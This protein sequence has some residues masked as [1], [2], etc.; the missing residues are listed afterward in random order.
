MSAIKTL[1]GQKKSSVN[2]LLKPNQ[3]NNILGTISVTKPGTIVTAFPKLD[4]LE[5]MKEI[6][7]AQEREHPEQFKDTFR[8]PFA[9]EKTFDIPKDKPLGAVAGILS[10][11]PELTVSLPVAA[12]NFVRKNLNTIIAGKPVETEQFKSILGFDIRRFGLN[13]K[14]MQ[15]TATAAWNQALE[16]EM[17]NPSRGDK[18]KEI[19]NATMAVSKTV[20]PDVLDALFGVD[21]AK[22]LL[23]LSVGG[24]RLAAKQLPENLLFKI[25]E[26]NISPQAVYDVLI[27]GNRLSNPVEFKIAIDFI[28]GLSV[29]ERIQ[30]W[31]VAKS[32]E[33]T[34]LPIPI[35]GKATPTA[36]GKFAGV[37]AP[38]TKLPSRISGL[39]SERASSQR[40]GFLN[41][42]AMGEEFVNLAKQAKDIK[43]FERLLSKEQIG[44]LVAKGFTV[45]T[46]FNT[47]KESQSL[48]IEARKYK[49]AEEFVKAQGVNPVLNLPRSN[50]QGVD[51][52]FATEKT[53]N[54]IHEFELPSGKKTYSI[55]RVENGKN[56]APRTKEKMGEMTVWESPRFGT[57]EEAQNALKKG[58]SSFREEGTNTTLFKQIES[59]LTETKSQLT[60]FYN[61]ATKGVPKASVE[62]KTRALTQEEF[63]QKKFEESDMREFDQ[64]ATYEPTAKTPTAFLKMEHK[65]EIRVIKK[66]IMDKAG[67]IYDSK[68]ANIKDAKEILSRRR[69]F[70]KAI[71]KQF[72]LSDADLKTITRRDIRLMSNVEFKEFLDNIRIKSE[73]LSEW[74]QAKNELV[75]QIREKELN[76]EPLRESMKL[77]PISKMSTSQ[78]QEFAQTLE[79]YMKSDIFLSKRKLDTIKLTELS[80][81]KTYR[82]ALDI[83]AKK[84]GVKPEDL[85]NIKISEFDRFKGHVALVEKDPFFRMMVEETTR[86]RLIREAEYLEIEGTMNNLA[87]KIKTTLLQKLIPQQKNIRAWFEATDKNTI[88]L[89]EE[90]ASVVKFMQEEWIRARDYLIKIKALQKG[91]KSDNYFT[92]IRRGILEAVKEDGIITAI[93]EVFQ[94]YNLDEQVFSIVDTETGQI[95]SMEKFFQFALRRTGGLIPTENIVG[96]FL[97]YMKTFKKKQ[98][99]D[100]IVPLIDIYANALTPK[101]LTESGLL[102]HGNLTRFIKEWLNTQKGSRITLMARHGGKI[103]WALRAGRTFT[104]LL[105]LG[106]NIPVTIATQI[107]E[108]AVQYQILGKG[109]FIRGKVRALTPRG[110]R[111]AKKY[112]N[113][114]GKNPWTQLIEPMRD[115]GDRLSE[116]MFV[117]FHDANVRRNRNIMLGLMIKEEWVSETLSPERLVQLKISIARYGVVSGVGSIVGATP[118]AGM[119]TQYKTWALPIIGSQLRNVS[120]MA[121]FFK[122]RGAQEGTR[123]R[124]ALLETYRMLELGAFVSIVGYLVLTNDDDDSIIGKLKKRAYQEAMTLFGATPVVF[125]VPRMATFMT[126]LTSSIASILK[127]EKY[128]T[129]KFGEYEA[130]DLKGTRQLQ[131]VLT[132]RAIKQFQGTKTK[133]IDDV[134]GEIKRDIESG[135]LTI[136]A[137]KE[138]LNNELSKLNT[139]EQKAR[140]NMTLDDYKKDIRERLENKEI[141][142]A[143]AKGEFIKYTEANID[144][145]RSPN[146]GSFIDK[147]ILH[148]KAIGT[149]PIT[150]FIF[151]FQGETIRKIENGTIIVER[152]SLQ[153]SQQ[154]KKELG[155]GELILDHTIPLELGGGNGKD[156]LKLVSVDEWESYTSVENYLGDKLRAGLIDKKTAQKLILQ[157]KDKEISATDIM[158]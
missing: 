3:D 128:K 49:S 129:S 143:E 29:K 10:R 60:D 150:A 17:R 48:I 149:D 58:T 125:S 79:P 38:A 147:I 158:K 77:P 44:L 84:L 99:L 138:K 133:T 57:L 81:I 19:V 11:V 34:G 64:G 13:D 4:P 139:A 20:V 127:L 145:F 108:Q 105:D 54:Y 90:E 5:T 39:L 152:M 151:L 74:K 106:L 52:Y 69:T 35:R 86:L 7:A 97:T 117:M 123:G 112:R 131:R 43:E 115:I 65:D 89:T 80:G 31:S 21:V 126:D 124:R 154:V 68:V 94:K 85:N 63:I 116:G 92:H 14:V 121:K 12:I 18:T 42:Q 55:G 50:N 46:F 30:L 76:I 61:K 103:D 71:Q 56:F 96:A 98:A 153:E 120:Y 136:A 27:G 104:T 28:R 137:A 118:E 47:A 9:K 22:G 6:Y 87:K 40:G 33:K 119:L 25:T 100:E 122:S 140:L 107:G 110:R 130:G 41:V 141:T 93:K 155:A 37:E 75:S 88:T 70:I 24:I 72:G 45:E 83:L 144:S 135:D 15:D 51:R 102:L 114:T 101:G 16:E 78:L 148:S 73:Q 23:K 67:A 26:N 1:L 134:R 59:K 95:L 132:P 66:E 113:L 156:N 32:Y 157:F 91:M 62:N 109:G 36:M 146:E 53:G 82:E 142:V 111:I 2:E 8:L